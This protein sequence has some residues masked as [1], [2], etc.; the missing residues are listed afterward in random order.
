[1]FFKNFLGKKMVE[2]L[3]SNNFRKK[4]SG[5]IEKGF[6]LPG[7]PAVTL[8]P[9]AYK[10]SHPGIRI[11]TGFI[12]KKLSGTWSEP[13]RQTRIVLHSIG[14]RVSVNKKIAPFIKKRIMRIL[15]KWP[16]PAIGSVDRP[17]PPLPGAGGR[18]HRWS[19]PQCHRR[20]CSSGH[21]RQPGQFPNLW[22][23]VCSGY[24]LMQSCCSCG[25]DPLRKTAPVQQL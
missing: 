5:K 19:H 20:S 17:S 22:G 21:C 11:N 18:L 16:L 12:L 10:I 4:L 6:L 7:D 25:L 8:F 14:I 15:Q 24:G 23:W 3:R 13:S 2:I 9:A 1:M